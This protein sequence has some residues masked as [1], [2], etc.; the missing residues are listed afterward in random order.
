VALYLDANVIVALLIQEPTSDAV[1]GLLRRSS[2]P[3]LVSEF[4]AAEVA[5]TMS[6]LVRMGRMTS[7]MANFTLADFDDWRAAD[8]LPI[9]IDDLDIAQAGAFVRR[10]ELKLRTPDAL[11]LAVCLR[12]GAQLVT[13]DGGLAEAAQVCGATVVQP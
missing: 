3:L 9:E 4:A 1:T 13:R 6:R 11:H 8:T 12:V 2:E 10:F 7:E 5:S